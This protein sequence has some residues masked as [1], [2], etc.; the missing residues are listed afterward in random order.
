DGKLWEYDTRNKWVDRELPIDSDP[1]GHIFHFDPGGGTSDKIHIFARNIEGNLVEWYKNGDTSGNKNHKTPA[2]S[3]LFFSPC[4][5]NVADYGLRVFSAS[6][7]NS[8]IKRNVPSRIWNEYKDPNETTLTPTL[9]WEYWNQKGWVVLKGLRDETTN[10][11]KSGKITFDLPDDI[12]EAEVAGQKSYWIRAR[13]V[14]GDYGKETF[15][16]AKKLSPYFHAIAKT[17]VTQQLVSTKTTIRPP[18][19]NS[20]AISYKLETKKWPHKTLAHNN[21]GYIDQTEASKTLGKHFAPFEQLD[22]RDKTLYLGFERSFKGGPVKIFFAARELPF[23]EAKKPKLQWLYSQENIWGELSHLDATEGLIKAD[24]LDLIAPSDFAARSGFGQYLYWVKGSLA[25]GEYE[26]SP[27]LDGIYPNTTWAIQ[28]ETIRDEIL[29]SSDAEPD[30]TFS[31]LKFPVLKGEEIRVREPLS[32]EEKQALIELLGE[33]AIYE[34]KDERGKVT[35]TW[36][37]YSEVP[38]FFDS[39]QKSRQYTLDRATGELRFGDGIKGMIPPAGDDNIKAFFY[40][41]GGGAQGNVKAGEIKTLKS[42]VGGVDKVLNNSAADGGADTATVDQMLKIGP[43]MISHRNRA[44]TAEDFEWLA[45]EA[46]RKV[47]RARC[48]PNTNNQ[49][50]REA[51]WVTVVIVPDSL[52][53]KPMPSLELKRKV[54]KYLEARCANTLAHRQHL[55][56]KGPSY[57]EIGTLADVYVTSMDVATEAECRVRSAL[58]AFFHPLSGGPEGE[59]WE[60][61]RNVTASDIYALLEPIEGVDHV[62]NVRF[63]CNGTTDEEIVEIQED[64]LVA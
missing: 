54:R 11:L 34:V 10:L 19:V 55:H 53:G 18:I 4:V 41:S 46:S 61:G 6:S 35:Q 25:K 63:S 24:M 20:L 56:V 5:L 48:L 59:G 7:N 52:E 44:V 16:L 26:Q 38:D 37:L 62:G 32:E 2:N 12:E 42:A 29:G 13:I 43:A 21:L 9:S 8:I 49:N 22:E 36:V 57:V 31:F 60:F 14:G 40:Q 3:K 47:A 50:A 28:A 64:F 1:H 51:G 23:T 30:Q 33:D 39:T 17:E 27:L 45:R 15:A 58:D